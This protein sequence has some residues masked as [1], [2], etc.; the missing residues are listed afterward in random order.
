MVSEVVSYGNLTV[1]L[2]HPAPFDFAKPDKWPKWIKHL[3]SGLSKTLKPDELA[4]F[5][6]TWEKRQWM[7]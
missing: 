1:T 3:A 6:T 4:L 7:F 5:T 2:Q